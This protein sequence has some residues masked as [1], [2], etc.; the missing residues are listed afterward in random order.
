MNGRINAKLARLEDAAAKKAARREAMAPRQAARPFDY[1]GFAA[2]FRKFGLA[3]SLP[4]S[5]RHA[6]IVQQYREWGVT[7]SRASEV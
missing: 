4:K 3:A 5:E 2:A 6:W 1:A 7:L